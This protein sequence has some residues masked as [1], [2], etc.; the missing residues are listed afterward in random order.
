MLHALDRS[1]LI[2]SHTHS[3]VDNVCLKLVDSGVKFMRLG[4]M[5]RIHPQLKEYS[6]HNLTR[7]CQTPDEL[8]KVYNSMVR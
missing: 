2:T 6:E 7:H 8:E 5:S 4:S 3:A 1:V